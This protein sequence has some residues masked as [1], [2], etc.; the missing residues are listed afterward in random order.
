MLRRLSIGCLLVPCLAGCS[1]TPARPDFAAADYPGTL[2]TVEALGHDLVWQQRVTASWG[3]GAQRGFDAAIQK[4]GDALTVMGLSPMGSLGFAIV[5]R[6][7]DIELSNQSGEELPFPPRFILLDVQRAFYPWL[8][9]GAGDEGTVDGEAIHELRRDGHLVQR[10]FRRLDGA[11]KGEI[12]VDY[13]WGHDDWVGPTRVVID[14]GWF[15]Y[16]LTVDTHTET[17]LAGG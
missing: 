1:S 11:P 14:N 12:V 7:G 3:D 9:A 17:L 10:R 5:L 4:R 15:G 13:E 16:R 8:P 2:R 6:D